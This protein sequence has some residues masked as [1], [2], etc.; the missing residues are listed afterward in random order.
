M[1]KKK[2]LFYYS[3]KE[4]I[5]NILALADTA[6]TKWGDKT[7]KNDGRGKLYSRSGHCCMR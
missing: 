5:Y 3:S 2:L 1:L 6:G 7:K 4:K